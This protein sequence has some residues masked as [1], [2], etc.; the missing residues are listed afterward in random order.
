MPV[1]FHLFDGS[2]GF[3]YKQ[4]YRIRIPT[5]R[6]TTKWMFSIS[7]V[8]SPFP[9]PLKPS[10]VT[11]PSHTSSGSH[12]ESNQSH[13]LKKEEKERV[14]KILIF[15]CMT[16]EYNEVQTYILNYKPFQVIRWIAISPASAAGKDNFLTLKFYC[17]TFKDCMYKC[18]LFIFHG[19]WLYQ[20][21]F[22][23]L[24]QTSSQFQCF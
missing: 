22:I 13:L 19:A 2:K 23:V 6:N 16:C 10:I 7:I 3:S 9:P 12:M 1:S 24:I 4:G 8:W 14:K 18:L 17:K 11:H 21:T 5:K 20:R 15:H